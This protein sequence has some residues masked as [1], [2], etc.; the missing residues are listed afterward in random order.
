MWLSS[1][2]S[3]ES[4]KLDMSKPGIPDAAA[5]KAPAELLPDPDEPAA[6]GLLRKSFTWKHP[7]YGFRFRFEM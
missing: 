4:R 7:K 2:W 5:A 1:E 6:G 3:S